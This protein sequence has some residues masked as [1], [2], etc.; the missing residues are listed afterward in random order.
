LKA[1]FFQ[2]QVEDSTWQ[3]RRRPR[4]HILHH[5][6]HLFRLPERGCTRRA[7]L[8]V[9]STAIQVLNPHR[10]CSTSHPSEDCRAKR[11]SHSSDT[12]AWGGLR[13][14][15]DP[16]EVDRER[17]QQRPS[18]D[19]GTPLSPCSVPPPAAISSH[20]T[21]DTLSETFWTLSPLLFA[22]A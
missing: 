5:L 22:L 2:I 3:A 4:C 15:R 12:P 14:R 7:H 6:L 20:D 8:R 17:R 18:V 10:S 13:S 21:Q 16:L 19:R 1:S 11:R 9:F